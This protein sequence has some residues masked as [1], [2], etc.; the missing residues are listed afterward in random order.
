DQY[1]R[2]FHIS[3]RVQKLKK[4]GFSIDRTHSAPFGCMRGL[5]PPLFSAP[6]SLFNGISDRQLGRQAD[7][8]P[9]TRY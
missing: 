8:F 1:D 2:H 6:I 3:I 5:R 4:A 9:F 7:I